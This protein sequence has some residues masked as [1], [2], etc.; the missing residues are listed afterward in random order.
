M[1]SPDTSPDADRVQRE[2]FARMSG[3]RRVELALEMSIAMRAVSADGIRSRHPEYQEVQVRHA[4]N[5]LIL[6]DRL[7]QQAWPDAPLL[8]P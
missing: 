5:R 4:L 1:R 8:P 2:V 3:E 7:F 6:G